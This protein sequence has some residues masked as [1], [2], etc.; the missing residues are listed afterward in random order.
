[1]QLEHLQARLVSGSREPRDRSRDKSPVAGK[2]VSVLREEIKSL[3]EQMRL[4]S[5]DQSRVG[6]A[7][8]LA[9]AKGQ[10]KELKVGVV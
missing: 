4:V 2:E 7:E 10:I 1:M 8:E 9:H 6:M 5:K 3:K